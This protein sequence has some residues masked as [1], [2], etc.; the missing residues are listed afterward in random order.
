MDEF[1]SYQPDIAIHI[2]NKLY[3]G[4]EKLQYNEEKHKYFSSNLLF[5]FQSHIIKEL[6]STSYN[7]I[8]VV[9]ANL[10]SVLYILNS[11]H[12][13]IYLEGIFLK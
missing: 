1:K 7:N 8:S 5:V 9:P 6:S 11:L 2:T 3:K 13:C 10:N 4:V 12:T